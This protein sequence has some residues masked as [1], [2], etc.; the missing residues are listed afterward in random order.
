MSGWI[1]PNLVTRNL[2]KRDE[3]RGD[4]LIRG[5]WERGWT[6]SLMYVSRIPMPEQSLEG[7]G[8]GSPRKE[9]GRIT[10]SPVLSNAVIS[11]CG[12][13]RRP[14]IGKEAKP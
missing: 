12:L 14:L 13:H 9:K 10:S 1:N 6:A 11:V 3:L 4:L 8:P 7:P 5:F 2:R